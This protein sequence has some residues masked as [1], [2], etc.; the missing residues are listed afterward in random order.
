MSN[1][2][3]ANE[4]AQY[5]NVS[6]RTVCSRLRQFGLGT[7][8]NMSTIH[9]AQLDRAI[10][11]LKRR[12]PNSGYRMMTSLLKTNS[13]IR[14]S[15]ARVYASMKRID[16]VGMA[17][18]RRVVLH[19]RQ[20]RVNGANSVWHLDANLKLSRWIF[21]VQ[22]C[23][24]GYSRAIIYLNCA[25]CNNTAITL[26]SFVRGMSHFG[27]PS[28]TRSD[29]G[30]EN[31]LVSRLMVGLQ[32]RGRGSHIVGRS[33][34]NQRIER[35]WRDV[36]TSVL[37]Q[38]YAFFYDMEDAGLLD[39]TNPRHILYL[40][41]SFGKLI[42]KELAT[43]A[44]GWNMHGL[45]SEHHLTPLRLWMRSMVARNIVLPTDQFCSLQD[46]AT[47][48]DKLPEFYLSE[49]DLH[50]FLSLPRANQRIF[51]NA[52]TVMNI[53]QAFDLYTSWLL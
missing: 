40:H 35:L 12:F 19:R 31:V 9:D 1:R 51:A 46:A 21:F 39:P 24:D 7:R 37:S 45:R 41:L 11:A 50:C 53:N 47:A 2:F 52:T 38:F 20:Y 3:T 16:P 10:L 43:F 36:Y 4:M 6:R 14:V 29:A 32:G 48:H 8:R 34:H 18:R 17:R 5:L 23:V 25:A 30:L 26:N 13:Q 22:G 27:L 44:R 28:R 33:V 15:K 42:C 49:S